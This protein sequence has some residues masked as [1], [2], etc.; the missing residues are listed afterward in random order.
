MV[1]GAGLPYFFTSALELR[2]APAAEVGPLL[3]GTMPLCVALIATVWERQKLGWLRGA[4]FVLIALGILSIAGFHLITEG[5]LSAGHLFAI[6]AAW[7]WAFYTIAFRRTG[8]NPLEGAAIVAGWSAIV[9]VPLGA[10]PVYQAIEAGQGSQLFMQAMIQGLASGAIA[11]VLYGYGVSVLGAPRAA[12][13]TALI[14]AMAAVLAIPMLGEWPDRSAIAG[15]VA[16]SIGVLLIN[17]PRK[18]P[19]A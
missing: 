15:I 10:R 19:A 7:M 16:V 2:L 3:P 14:P 11:L 4:G 6:S 12:A 18:E 5:H 9:A 1:I 17:W 8:L 13:F